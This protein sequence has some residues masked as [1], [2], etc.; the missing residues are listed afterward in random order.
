MF[1]YFVSFDDTLSHSDFGIGGVVAGTT[2]MT[3]FIEEVP[4]FIQISKREFGP[5]W[6]RTIWLT[7]SRFISLA[8]SVGNGIFVL[9]FE[10][11]VSINFYI[12]MESNQDSAVLAQQIQALAAIVEELTR[13]NQ[14]MKLWIQQEE[15]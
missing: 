3:T 10:T 2:S 13:Q 15:N 5:V 6:A 7:N 8:P 12:Q 14:E 4:S 11:T 9:R 1:C